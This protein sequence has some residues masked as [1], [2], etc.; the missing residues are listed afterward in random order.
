MLLKKYSSSIGLLLLLSLSYQSAHADLL[1]VEDAAMLANAVKQLDQLKE[2]Y[3]LIDK[4]YKNAES[5]LNSA[6]KLANFNSG[7]SGF[8]R[9]HNSLADLQ[10]RQSADSWRETLKGVSGGN[11]ERY[12][13]LVTAYEKQHATLNKTQFSRGAVPHRVARFEEERQI[14]QA[15]SIESEV[16]FNDINVSLQRIH[17]LSEEIEK[18]EST[19]AAIDLNSRLLTE[20][21]YLAVQNLKAQSLINQQLAMKG[22][23][24]L[25]DEAELAQY[26]TLK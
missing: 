8:G 5:Q 16:A 7:H 6:N 20:I 17:A 4:S 26:L 9:L 23:S 21:A 18:A 15:A 12:R 14:T 1:G 25:T 22:S 24:N 10:Q 11:P 19:K 3:R 2:Q 13:E